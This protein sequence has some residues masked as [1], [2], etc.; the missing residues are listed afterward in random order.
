MMRRIAS[1]RFCASFAFILNDAA[2]SGLSA[3][4][5]CS[6]RC[7]SRMAL[8]STERSAFHS[9]SSLV[10]ASVASRLST[11]YACPVWQR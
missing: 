6:P 2:S 1:T 7:A 8:S 4:C 10:S 9:A 5:A 3:S 11:E